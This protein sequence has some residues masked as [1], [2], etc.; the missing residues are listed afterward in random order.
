MASSP[1]AI[2]K[3]ESTINESVV[4]NKNNDNNVLDEPKME[5][6]KSGSDE[7]TNNNGLEKEKIEKE[8]NAIERCIVLLNMAYLEDS[9]SRIFQLKKG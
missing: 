7:N 8:E 1:T 2:K 5:V 4:E 6:N 9:N 3:E